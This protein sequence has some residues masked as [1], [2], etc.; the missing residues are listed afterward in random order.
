MRFILTEDEIS[1]KDEEKYFFYFYASWMPFHKKM[2]KMISS[3]EDKYKNEINF[4]AIDVDYFKNLCIRFDIKSIPVI[5][6]FKDKKE[7]SRINGLIMSSALKNVMY[8]LME[9]KNEI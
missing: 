8:K 2:L 3:M 4:F 6:I 5:L 1:F 7:V 9:K